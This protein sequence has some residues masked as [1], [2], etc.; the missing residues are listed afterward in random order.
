MGLR[1]GS[2]HFEVSLNEAASPEPKK[3]PKAP[4]APCV[5]S[6]KAAR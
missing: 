3:P 5:G 2:N 6:L 1:Y 4:S